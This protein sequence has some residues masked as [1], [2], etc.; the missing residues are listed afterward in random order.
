MSNNQIPPKGDNAV[1]KD[2]LGSGFI[3]SVPKLMSWLISRLVI[4]VEDDEVDESSCA[5]TLVTSYRTSIAQ[6]IS[7]TSDGVAPP[8]I[9]L[10]FTNGANIDKDRTPRRDVVIGHNEATVQTGQVDTTKSVAW[11]PHP[12]PLALSTTEENALYPYGGQVGMQRCICANTIGKRLM[13]GEQ[14]I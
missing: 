9:H 8:W 5:T 12:S 7:S 1:L 6:P 2:W 10:I 11:V 13:K 3:T 4:R 14:I